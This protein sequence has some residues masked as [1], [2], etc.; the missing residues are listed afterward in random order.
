[1]SRLDLGESISVTK[2]S[3]ACSGILHLDGPHL[4]AN[5]G[6]YQHWPEKDNVHPTKG[7]TPCYAQIYLCKVLQNT[8]RKTTPPIHTVKLR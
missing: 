8:K 4:D 7:Q 3:L 6:C 5:V 2:S 1:M